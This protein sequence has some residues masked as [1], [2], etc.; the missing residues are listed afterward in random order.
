MK[1]SGSFV[2]AADLELAEDEHVEIQDECLTNEPRDSLPKK[3]RRR[4]EYF[5]FYLFATLV[6]RRPS[7]KEMRIR[8]VISVKG[9]TREIAEKNLVEFCARPGVIRIGA[10]KAERTEGAS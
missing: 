10:E 3:V 5:E 9:L 2:E 6:R 4:A 8:I 1:R 7:R